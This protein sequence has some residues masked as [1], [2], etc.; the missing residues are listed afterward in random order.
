M[1]DIGALLGRGYPVPQP[2]GKITNQSPH[3]DGGNS[4]GVS[5]T[6]ANRSANGDE[7]TILWT[8]AA[9]VL[10]ALAILWFSGAFAFRSI[11]L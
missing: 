5:G 9:I 1:P 8:S 10:V 7:R 2:T 3:V 4:P 6:M 11:R